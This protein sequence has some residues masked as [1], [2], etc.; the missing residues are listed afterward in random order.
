MSTFGIEEEFFLVH[1]GT[2]FP[3]VPDERTVANILG[4]T[5]GGNSS[6][7]EMLA[8]QVETA[9]AICTEGLGA[10]ASLREY[11]KELARTVQEAGLVA[12]ASERFRSTLLD[13]P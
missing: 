7:T 12:V 2:G 11:R 6:H 3:A 13:P 4:I 8:C 10:L 1:P 5:A 9:T